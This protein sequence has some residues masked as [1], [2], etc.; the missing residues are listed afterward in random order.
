MWLVTIFKY[1]IVIIIIC[2]IHYASD[3]WLELMQ[4]YG[5]FIVGLIIYGICKSTLA[6]TVI[7]PP[8]EP[9]G[10]NE[11][12]LTPAELARLRIARSKERA[13]DGITRFFNQ[14]S[15]WA[16]AKNSDTGNFSW[17]EEPF[18]NIEQ[19]QTINP[20]YKLPPGFTDINYKFKNN[21]K[22]I[23]GV[24]EFCEDNPT[25]YPCHGWTDIGPPKCSGTYAQ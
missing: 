9:R 13:S 8:F 10:H 2:I 12:E 18:Q 21:K 11:A 6:A 19:H 15:D 24:N 7:I 20:I 1:M 5:F 25:C 4:G 17:L 14:G 22:P 3:T 16:N 23:W